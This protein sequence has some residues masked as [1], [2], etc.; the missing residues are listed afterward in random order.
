LSKRAD[1][2][3]VRNFESRVL[4]FYCNWVAYSDSKRVGVNE[5]QYPPNV[6][7][8]P[9]TCSGIMAPE[10]ILEALARGLDRVFIAACPCSSNACPHHREDC[11]ASY[12]N[13][14][15]LK[16]MFSCLGTEPERIRLE[17]ISAVEEPRFVQKVS[18][19]TEEM[20]KLGPSHLKKNGGRNG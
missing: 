14:G 1:A 20:S 11:S 12:Y 8:L 16:V 9:V 17:R 13:V 15:R 18:H 4:A 5:A 10:T 2:T 19:F 7:L 6:Y 3:P